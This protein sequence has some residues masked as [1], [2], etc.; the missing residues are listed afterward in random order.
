M[1]IVIDRNNIITRADSRNDKEILSLDENIEVIQTPID[2]FK[3]YNFPDNIQIDTKFDRWDISTILYMYQDL[4]NHLL[5]NIECQKIVNQYFLIALQ[6]STANFEDINIQKI[7]YK[8]DIDE[9]I[10]DIVDTIKGIKS[11]ALLRA[12]EYDK[13]NNTIVSY[14]SREGIWEIEGEF[15]AKAIEMRSIGAIRTDRALRSVR[16]PTKFINRRR[17]NYHLFEDT[18]EL[19]ENDIIKYS[20]CTREQ[21]DH[22]YRDDTKTV[23]VTK[24]HYKTEELTTEDLQELYIAVDVDKALIEETTHINKQQATLAQMNQSLENNKKEIHT[25]YNE[26]KVISNNSLDKKLKEQKESV[27]A[28]YLRRLADELEEKQLRERAEL[29]KK[30]SIAFDETHRQKVKQILINSL[31]SGM[32]LVEALENLKAAKYS[33][34]IIQTVLEELKT[35]MILSVKKDEL[36]AH[37]DKKIQKLTQDLE[38]ATKK[39]NEF[40]RKNNFNYKNYTI[41]LEK[42]KKADE[43]IYSMKNYID[44]FKSTIEK[45]NIEIYDLQKELENKERETNALTKELDEQF[46]KLQEQEKLLKYQNEQIETLLLRVAKME[47][48]LNIVGDLNKKIDLLC[49]QN[50]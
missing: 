35:D 37:K 39:A 48:R 29:E 17:I 19:I 26:I 9:N 3:K 44:Q 47:E 6:L 33:N 42:R 38:M 36:I 4:R 10:D 50:K 2:L 23:Y 32:T 41:E 13:D 30:I 24:L 8:L 16:E 22:S 20:Y 15:F 12:I 18:R 14:S 28:E 43:T 46:N 11:N 27:I 40:E 45:K 25:K 34:V 49:S 31:T 7:T 1:K 5:N 21:P